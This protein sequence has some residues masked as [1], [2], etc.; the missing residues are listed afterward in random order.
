MNTVVYNGLD[1]VREMT[2]NTLLATEIL[3][4]YE[5]AYHSLNQLFNDEEA[6]ELRKQF[7]RQNIKVRELTNADKRE[8]IIVV[9]GFEKIL[10]VRRIDPRL[11]TYATEV[12]IYNDVVAFY[13][14]GQESY[15]LEIYDENYSRMQ[16]EIFD[17]LWEQVSVPLKATNTG[18]LA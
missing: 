12:V 11:I 16:A 10:Q 14:Y 4:I 5:I 7:V 17:Q 3:R 6:T 1:R 9:P 13:T 2:Y 18:S 8:A 15:G